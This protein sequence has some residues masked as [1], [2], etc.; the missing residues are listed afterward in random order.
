MTGITNKD[1]KKRI[2][3]IS[4][5]HKLS[6][7]GSC[8]TA[9]DIIKEI[10]DKKKEDEKFVLSAGHAAL[11]LYVVNEDK[12]GISAEKAF[13]HH[14]VHPD[15]CSNCRL[16][17][18]SGSLG[19]GLGIALGMALADRTKDVYCLISDGECSEGSIWEAL[20]I[21]EEQRLINLNIY[22]NANGWGAYKGINIGIIKE[23]LEVFSPNVN[24]RVAPVDVYSFMPGQD[25]HYHVM[26][27]E[28]YK[29][30][31]EILK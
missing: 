8:L 24:L 3:E 23:Q 15:R 12:Y 13:E 18:S 6:H 31:L 27:D 21:A 29:Q 7:L 30:G 19:N 20:R 28:E 11:A 16:D 4:Y 2:L 9:I 10:Y 25:A 14:G 26:T 1:L 5:K 22:C 17:S